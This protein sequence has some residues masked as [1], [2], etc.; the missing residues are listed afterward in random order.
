[1]KI[2][3]VTPRSPYPVQFK[4][5]TVSQTFPELVVLLGMKQ[6]DF[7]L[8]DE[9]VDEREFDRFITD[10]K[11]DVV[12]LTSITSTYPR[13]VKLSRIARRAGVVSVLGGVFPTLVGETMKHATSDFDTVVVGRP[14]RQIF[15]RLFGGEKTMFR[16]DAPKPSPIQTI[17][18]ANHLFS[19]YYR[20]STMSVSITDGCPHDCDFC[21]LRRAWGRGIRLSLSERDIFSMLEAA[22]TCWPRI[23]IIDEDVL[24]AKSA[25]QAV[26]TFPAFESITA[27]TRVDRL[28]DENIDI[29]DQMGVDSLVV[30]VETFSVSAARAMSKGYP[31]DMSARKVHSSIEKVVSRGIRVR[32]VI[33]LTSFGH[34]ENDLHE[35]KN[36]LTDWTPRNGIDVLFSFLT[37]HPPLVGRYRS[38]TLLTNDLSKFDHLHLVYLPPSLEAIPPQQILDHYERLVET[39]DSRPFNPVLKVETTHTHEYAEFFSPTAA[40]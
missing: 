6:S 3:L 22:R 31:S 27:E 13:A 12:F 38:G 9:N 21:T 40:Q 23:K 18:I 10:E 29:L 30:G 35:L 34:S 15:E 19:D 39:T 32:P 20:G 26:G 14:S 16:D 11:I 5:N 17:Q 4:H 1:M 33:M 24:L 36:H 25:L 7:S 8:Y 37:P 2:G 28:T